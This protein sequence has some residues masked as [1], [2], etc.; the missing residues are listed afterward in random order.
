MLVEFC[1]PIYNEEKIIEKNV[2][3]I[4]NFC[5]E[6]NLPFN[7]RVIIVNN[8]SK[9]NSL[10]ISQKLS[11]DN[12]QI[13]YTTILEPGRGQALKKYWLTSNAD[14][15]AYM[16]ADLA[17]SLNNIIDLINPFVNNEADLVIGSRM[18]PGAT[19]KRS[20]IRELISQSCNILYR[21][22][23]GNNISDTQCG[24]KAIKT[25]VFKKIAPYIEDNKWFFDTEIISFTHHLGY[26]I[27]E[28]PVNWEENRYDERKSK[29]NLLKDSFIH[30][31][32]LLRLKKRLRGIKS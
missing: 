1:L 10:A 21:L 32:N 13:G 11:A 5:K 7:W 27:K 29:V 17:V 8:G 16:D 20:F 30:L 25:E 12:K 2:L 26:K 24:F 18:M 15:V 14:V 28:V 9:D 19:I 6:K 31:K 4:V 22:I 3:K 23:I